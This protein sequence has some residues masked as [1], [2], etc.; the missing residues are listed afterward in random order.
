[1]VNMLFGSV[2]FE[3][4]LYDL[5]DLNLDRALKDAEKYERSYSNDTT[6]NKWLTEFIATTVSINKLNAKTARE[7]AF[8]MMKIDSN[9]ISKL[10]LSL[11]YL[12]END[13]ENSM[14]IATDII[15]NNTNSNNLNLFYINE[16]ALIYMVASMIL[17]SSNDA[18]DALDLLKN[19]ISEDSKSRFLGTELLFESLIYLVQNENSRAKADLTNAL[20]LGYRSN[21]KVIL[22][23][24]KLANNKENDINKVMPL[25]YDLRTDFIKDIS[26]DLLYSIVFK[27]A[28]DSYYNGRRDQDSTGVTAFA[29]AEK[30]KERY[31][32]LVDMEKQKDELSKYLI[33]PLKYSDNLSSYGVKVGG[34]ILLYGPPGCGKTFVV[35]ATAGEADVRFIDVKIPDVVDALVGN[36]EKNIHNLFE[37]ARENSPSIIF[38]DELDALGVSRNETGSAPWM[39]QAVNTMLSEM[40]NLYDKGYKV[41]VVGATNEP[42]LIDP[43]LRRSG[44]FGNLIYAPPPNNDVRA[45]LFMMYLKGKPLATDI[46]FNKLAE[47]AK[48]ASHSDIK[49]ICDDASREVWAKSIKTNVKDLQISMQDIVDAISKAKFVVPEWYAESAE[50]LGSDIN[51]YPELKDDIIRY[52][53]ENNINPNSDGDQ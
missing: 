42:W 43:A 8:K 16:K 4:I 33:Y 10:L 24:L 29:S 7:Y 45:K 47:L 30:P 13:Y 23:I 36:T 26:Y 39:R 34:G 21:K 46:D 52:M 18:K 17:F 37:Y 28:K 38:F 22:D 32:D 49:S 20:Q 11:S 27:N 51:S 1:M 40:N 12:I 53:K 6:M 5:K 25:F 44:R 41:L 3:D 9:D 35:M 48:N 2:K 15:Q 19:S 31:S 14:K 50:A